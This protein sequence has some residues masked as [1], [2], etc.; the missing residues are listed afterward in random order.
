MS[1][2]FVQRLC[3]ASRRRH[4]VAGVFSGVSTSS[5]VTN[6]IALET[7]DDGYLVLRADRKQSPDYPGGLSSQ[8]LSAATNV[9]ALAAGRYQGLAVKRDGK[10]VDFAQTSAG[11]T[12]LSGIIG[13]ASTSSGP[14]FAVRSDGSVVWGG[15]IV[16]AATNVPY[17][18]TSVRVLD[19]GYSHCLALLSGPDFPPVF[20]QNTLNTS[21]YVVSSKGSPQWFGQTNVIYMMERTRPKA[22]PSATT[23]RPPC[24][25]GLPDRSKS[26]SGGKFLP[27]PTTAS[28]VFPH[29]GNVLTNISGE[30]DWQPCT[31]AVPP[32]NQILQSTYSKDGSAAAGQDAA[33]VNKLQFTN[34]PPTI[35]GAAA[36]GQ[37]GRCGRNECHSHLHCD[38]HRHAAD[39]LFSGNK[40]GNTVASRIRTKPIWCWPA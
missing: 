11:V 39:V 22:R 27:P 28:W 35:F 29:G 16:N 31:L 23:P 15:S 26:N 20:L 13:V 3:D 33:W 10:V 6:G 9:L 21:N 32:G 37:S 19:A 38:G 17:G 14:E 36:T 1:H 18:L 40:N 2:F 5:G 12:D 24:A 7:C 4:T 25:R 8:N 30:V 34:L